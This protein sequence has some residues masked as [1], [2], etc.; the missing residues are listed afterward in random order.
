LKPYKEGKVMKFIHFQFQT[1]I[2]WPNFVK[3]TGATY[4]N[5]SVAI[6]DGGQV[7]IPDYL[8]FN[9]QA[10][11]VQQQLLYCCSYLATAQYLI[12]KI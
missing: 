3:R 7:I 2:F 12:S 6:K 11:L 5:H 9:G 8:E 10:L 4:K 1:C